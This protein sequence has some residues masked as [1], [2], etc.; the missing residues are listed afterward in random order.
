MFGKFISPVILPHFRQAT[1]LFLRVGHFFVRVKR[2]EIK[3]NKPDEIDEID[4][5]KL[6]HLPKRGTS[7]L[8]EL[9]NA[10][11]SFFDETIN[12]FLL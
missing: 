2:S 3:I 12:S 5:F 4:W 6:G 1:L 7:V 11:E 8:R 9:L 10:S